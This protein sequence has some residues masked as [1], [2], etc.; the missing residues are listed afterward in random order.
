MQ[1]S[2]LKDIS[3]SFFILFF[4]SFVYLI[5]LSLSHY[6]KSQGLV[7]LQHVQSSSL[8]GNRTLSSPIGST[9]SQ[10]LDQEAPYLRVFIICITQTTLF[11][12]H[13]EELI[14]L[15]FIEHLLFARNHVKIFSYIVSVIHFF[16]TIFVKLPAM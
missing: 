13:F 12:K 10:P 15:I 4:F 7:Y 9:E 6:I 5:A 11:K 1:I 8:T 3:E 14:W 2:S 16:R